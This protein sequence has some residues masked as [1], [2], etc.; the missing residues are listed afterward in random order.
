VAVDHVFPRHF[1]IERLAIRRH[2]LAIAIDRYCIIG[3]DFRVSRAADARVDLFGQT[4]AEHTEALAIGSG[5]GEPGIGFQRARKIDIGVALDSIM[6]AALCGT[7]IIL[8]DAS[9]MYSIM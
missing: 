8:S 4:V 7:S 2:H 6:S 3:A 9:S 1:A 5:H